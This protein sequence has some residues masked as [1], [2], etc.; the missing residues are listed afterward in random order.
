MNTDPTSIKD[1]AKRLREFLETRDSNTTLSHAQSLEAISR[2]CFNRSWQEVRLLAP[3]HTRYVTPKEAHYLCRKGDAYLSASHPAGPLHTAQIFTSVQHNL[4]SGPWESYSFYPASSEAKPHHWVIRNPESYFRDGSP[5]Y[6]SHNHTQVELTHAVC[7][8]TKDEA[9]QHSHTFSDTLSSVE[10]CYVAHV[11]SDTPNPAALSLA[12]RPETP[13]PDCHE[14]V[15]N[16]PDSAIWL[17]QG[18]FS[19]YTHLTDE[20]ISV[21]IYPRGS[22]GE[23]SIASTYAFDSENP[24]LIR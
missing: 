10:P 8:K 20:G 23:D 14:F 17:S 22:M 5:S 1:A 12:V 13:H 24:A 11:Q 9:T 15:A 18:A 7:F 6:Y 3:A 4:S 19:I 2:A 21:D 16:D